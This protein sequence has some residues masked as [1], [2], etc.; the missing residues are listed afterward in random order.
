MKVA[1]PRGPILTTQLYFP[2]VPQNAS[3]AIFDPTTVVKLNRS[4]RT[5]KATFDFVVRR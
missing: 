4:G 2:G 3:D 5:C 1:A